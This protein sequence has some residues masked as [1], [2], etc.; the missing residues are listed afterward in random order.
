MT[1]GDSIPPRQFWF[2]S[3]YAAGSGRSTNA[4]I[5]EAPAKWTFNLTQSPSITDGPYVILY[6][7]KITE[8]QYTQ[9]HGAW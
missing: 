5:D 3:F 2:V 4:V 1:S 9:W 8:A 7:E 6:A